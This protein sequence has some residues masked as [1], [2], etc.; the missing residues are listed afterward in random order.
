M[1]HFL[2]RF[3][4]HKT[5]NPSYLS[6]PRAHVRLSAP[7]ISVAGW[8]KVESS[9]TFLASRTHF[10]LLGLGLERQVLGHGFGLK[11]SS[12][13]KLPYPQLEDSSKF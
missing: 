1:R 2:R 12:P 13:R 9:R 4:V 8:I 6:W 7:L 11:A 10:D 5:G 3:E